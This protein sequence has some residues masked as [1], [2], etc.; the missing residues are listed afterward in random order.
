MY[1]CDR[2]INILLPKMNFEC[3][4]PFLQFDSNRQIQPCSID[5]R[6]DCVFWRN[7]KGSTIDLRKPKLMEF[8]PSLNWKE[9]ILEEGEC[10]TLKPGDFILGRIYEVFTM[11]PGNAG[12]IAGRSSFARM[13]LSINNN[14]DFINPGWR[15]HMPL[16]LVNHSDFKIKIFPYIP[17]CQ[18]HIIPL[19]NESNRIYGHEELYNKYMNDNGG[20]SHWWRDKFI[21]DLCESLRK[22]NLP[23]VIFNKFLSIMSPEDTEIIRRFDK[24]I[25]TKQVDE[26]TNYEDLMSGFIQKERKRIVFRKMVKSVSVGLFPSL[27]FLSIE[28]SW[29]KEFD[30]S[31]Y[32][33]WSLTIL[34]LFFCIWGSFYFKVGK[35]FEQSENNDT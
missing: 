12:K 30:F 20:P 32:L 34:S 21:R 24:F 13:G 26:I 17:I 33:L 28:L 6:L 35:S 8:S 23:D 7:K 2:D 25:S 19:S 9:I 4:N 14:G 10:I 27:L 29:R 5:L 3:E 18:L 31:L 11:P 15:G 22:H 1:L 16:Q